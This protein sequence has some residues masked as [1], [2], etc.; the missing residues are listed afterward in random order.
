M[1]QLVWQVKEK[2]RTQEFVG[3][4]V[5]SFD[6]ASVHES[7]AR[8][9]D[10]G[11]FMGIPF[12]RFP[13]AAHMPDGNQVV[14]HVFARIKPDTKK[15]LQQMRGPTMTAAMAQTA[16]R[17]EFFGGITRQQIADNCASLPRTLRMIATEKG[18]A[19]HWRDECGVYRTYHGTG[20][21]WPEA[22]YR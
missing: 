15:R 3:D 12:A 2:I 4:P 7:F 16:V 21:D 5:F 1:T 9:Y 6:H 8:K 17:T 11:E 13:L 14:E 18:V 19:F 22:R 10:G 20:G